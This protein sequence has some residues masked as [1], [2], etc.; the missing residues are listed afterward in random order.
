ML[1]EGSNDSFSYMFSTG[2]SAAAPA[3]VAEKAISAIH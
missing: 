1:L 3:T 2:L